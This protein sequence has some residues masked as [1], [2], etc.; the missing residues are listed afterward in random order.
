MQGNGYTEKFR[1]SKR[2]KKNKPDK[3]PKRK[4]GH[5]EHTQKNSLS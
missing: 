1:D 4:R 2:P 5:H 3:Q